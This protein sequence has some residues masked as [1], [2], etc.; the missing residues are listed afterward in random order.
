[1]GDKPLTWTVTLNTLEGKVLVD[2]PTFQGKE[3]AERRARLA[4]VAKR[5]YGDFEEVTVVGSVLNKAA[6]KRHHDTT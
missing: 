1:M 5:I 4:L 3:A 6:G 2:V